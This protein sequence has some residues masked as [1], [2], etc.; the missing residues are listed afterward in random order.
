MPVCMVWICKCSD[1]NGPENR[2]VIVLL[3]L[4]KVDIPSIC[5]I[6]NWI[7]W[8]WVL[9]IVSGFDLGFCIYAT[10]MCC[11][12]CLCALPGLYCC[13]VL[14]KILAV[15]PIFPHIVPWYAAF[16]VLCFRLNGWVL[17]SNVEVKLPLSLFY[18]LLS[19]LFGL[20]VAVTTLAYG[21][22]RCFLFLPNAICWCMPMFGMH[23]FPLCF[24]VSSLGLSIF[25]CAVLLLLYLL[26]VAS[27]YLIVFFVFS[28][29]FVWFSLYF[30]FSPTFCPLLDRT[31]VKY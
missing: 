21:A 7:V 25:S 18:W 30:L 27:L 13:M 1:L 5:G 8:L 22:E 26:L 9:C 2:Y 15:M 16:R 11:C 29:Y 6:L 24:C 17:L 4:F 14:V 3:V 28:L 31:C 23:H 20:Y 10:G 19:L 12:I